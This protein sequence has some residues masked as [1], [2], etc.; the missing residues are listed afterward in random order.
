MSSCVLEFAP[1]T[2]KWWNKPKT[3]K[4]RPRALWHSDQIRKNEANCHSIN[5]LSF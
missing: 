1:P 4:F 3:L 2:A 5:P